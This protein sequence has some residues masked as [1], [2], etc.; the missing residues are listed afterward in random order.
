MIRKLKVIPC[1]GIRPDC[2]GNYLAGLGLIAALSQ[3]WP[4]TR[5]CW[6]DGSLILMHETMDIPSM[7]D[8]LL[9][10]WRHSPYERWWKNEQKSDTKAKSDESLWRERSR[11]KIEYVRLLDSH[12]VGAGRNQFNPILGTGGNIGKRDF[13]NA[14]SEAFSILEKAKEKSQGWLRVTL[15]G[16]G[17][18]ELPEFNNAGTWFVYANKTYNSGQSWYRE[19]EISPWSFILALE[20]AKLLTGS[21][22]RRLSARSRPYAV[23][24]FITESPAP[25]SDGEIGL[26]KAEF[27]AP[28]W[29]QP[30]TLTEIKA[31]LKRGMAH[32]G[33]RA[34]KTP[35]EFAVAAMA[36]GVDT[37]VSDFMR[38]SLRQ[39]TSSQVYEAITRERVCVNSYES[40]ESKLIE[41]ILPWIDRLPFEPSDSKQ[42][43]KFR[44]LRGPVEQAII[45]V[46]AR[47]NDDELWRKL[48]LCLAE[49]QRKID[50]NKNLRSTCRAIPLLKQD[51]FDK[52]WP[53][54]RPEILLASTIASIGTG[55]DTPIL[56]NIY[57]VE[58]DRRGG[59]RFS[60]EQKPHRAIWNNGNLLSVL[61]G[62][63]ERRLVD[64]D[65]QSPLPLLATCTCPR[66]I[67]K[68]FLSRSLDLDLVKCWIPALSLI[69][70][71]QGYSG[72]FNRNH[73]MITVSDGMYMLH[74]LFRPIFHSHVLRVD[75]RDLFPDHLMPRS[76]L[77]RRLLYLIR[78]GSINE[79]VQLVRNRYLAAEHDIIMPPPGLMID[80]EL[81]AAAMLVPVHSSD[82][83]AGIK[84]WLK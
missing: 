41:H 28:L 61:T 8:F 53:S 25:I 17:S 40:Q 55:T 80:G 50:S 6:R 4:S 56:V 22:G 2:L 51:W 33:Q 77:A 43:G 35:H 12:I 48:L 24:P 45:K 47:P 83:S 9:Q 32:I 81:M 38:F 63:I 19:G 78:Q 5:G 42:R 36:A 10:A 27:W 57:G 59:T 11:V 44:G 23:F 79:A 68:A 82:V 66:E 52:C 76:V 74:A 20:G 3:K 31:L 39:T 7:E 30:A 46:A 54:P 60:G 84:R 72:R 37:G 69:K 18:C 15:H 29:G 58:V 1:H 64:A 34:A 14:I 70:W 71:E 62:L 16:K 73:D 67:L 65:A 26:T 21:T 13:Q 49:T 75:G